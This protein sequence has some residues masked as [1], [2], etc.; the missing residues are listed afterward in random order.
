MRRYG[1]SGSVFR[2]YEVN[3]AFQAAAVLLACLVALL[4]TSQKAEATFP[5]K[6]GKKIAYTVSKG[7]DPKVYSSNPTARRP[8]KYAYSTRDALF[9]TS[10]GFKPSSGKGPAYN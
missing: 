10:Q 6:N 9:E 4:A 7:N 3:A 1:S 8:F 5:G 2:T